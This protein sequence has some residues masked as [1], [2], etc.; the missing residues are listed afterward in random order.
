M[1]VQFNDIIP[2]KEITLKFLKNK[3]VAIDSMNVLY[4][5]LSSI[6]LRDGSPLTNSKG[7]IT[8]TYN[9]VFYKTIHML[10]NN[11][12]PVWV[13]DGVAPVLKEKTREER[14]KIR[15]DALDSYLEAKKK[16]D[17][18]EMQKY[19]KRANFLDS[20]I[21]ENSKKLLD[22]MGIPYINAPSEGEAQCAHMVKK[23]DAF[24]VVSQ[25]YDAILYGAERI[26]R[27]MTSNK[28]I[29]LIELKDVL[30]EL[31]LDLDQI[32]NI[33]ILIGTDYNPGGIKGIG[34]KKA[35][36]IVK[37]NKVQNY[38]DKIENYEEIYNI[39]KNPAVTDEYNIKL[40]TPKKEELID[41]LVNK[42][43][44][45]YDRI[46]PY[47]DKLCKII[48]EKNTQTSLEAWF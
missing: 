22:L 25:D 1:G 6:R 12:T 38:I 4:Q 18:E 9:G 29:E 20:T 23:G 14:R 48:E 39:F 26:V 34:P 36:E 17:I 28:A 31:D 3:T 40:K 35:L 21:V 16:D 13:F 47:V 2:R 33:A 42:N 7:E 46:V 41:F 30:K 45:S 27:N 44:F 5:F 19:A 15:Q 11:I 8:S 10:E 37:N 32:I 24:V 43:D